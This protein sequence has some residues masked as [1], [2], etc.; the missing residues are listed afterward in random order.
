MLAF[1]H[2]FCGR[3]FS[4]RGDPFFIRVFL[5]EIETGKFVD[6]LC[7]LGGCHACTILFSMDK[8]GPLK[9]GMVCAV[10]K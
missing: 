2:V 10:Y 3:R 4:N 9:E 8:M 5:S 6:F 7:D 1:M